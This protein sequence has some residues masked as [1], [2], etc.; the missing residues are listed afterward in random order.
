MLPTFFVIG[1]EKAGTTWLY[2]ILSRHPDIFLP[3]TK[4]L[5]YFNQLDSNL[6][7]SDY[8]TQ[9]KRS[10]YE[11]FF[12]ARRTENAVG[13]I[14]PMYLCDEAAPR[15]IADTV[16]GAK[17]IAILRDPVERAASHYWMAHNKR[18][19]AESLAETIAR[20]HDAV[21][22]RGLYGRQLTRYL[23]CFPR[24]QILILVFEEAMADR[25]RA[26]AAICRFIGVDPSAQPEEGLEEAS[27]P[28]TAYRWPWLYNASVGVATALRQAPLL[29]WIPRL[30]KKAGFN[31]LVKNA[32]AVD[33][34]KP[35]L[36]EEQRRDLRDYYAPDRECL[37][38]LMGRKIYV[39]PT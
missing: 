21:I 28:A 14:S 38:A 1:A 24:S 3:E 4:E 22:K 20:R 25:E 31:K 27:N 23:E 26:L 39:W 30:L 6:K 37:E 8:F 10:W 9:L 32:N 35:P 16:P 29:S 5:S 36:T 15:R 33:F 2:E 12:A 13:D 17:L 34:S 19:I 7:V 11:D 18:H